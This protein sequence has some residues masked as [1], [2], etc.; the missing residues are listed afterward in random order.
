MGSKMKKTMAK[1]LEL[2][3]KYLASLLKKDWKLKI[4]FSSTHV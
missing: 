2:Y 4:E 3:P 1:S